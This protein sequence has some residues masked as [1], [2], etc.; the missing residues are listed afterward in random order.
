MV[1]SGPTAA[2][3]SL[4][5]KINF[6]ITSATSSTGDYFFH[7]SSPANTTSVFFQRLFA[8]GTAGGFQLGING[9]QAAGSAAYG[10]TA[11][12]LNTDHEVV[13]K[14][15]FFLGGTNDMLYLYVNPTDPVLTNNIVYSSTNWTTTEPTT[16]A[17]AAGRVATA[18]RPPKILLAR[19][20]L[21]GH[22]RPFTARAH[23]EAVCGAHSRWM[24]ITGS[25]SGDV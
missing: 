5:M 20:V 9:A 21:H 14:W 16:V 2:G 8:R 17:G 11:L 7:L 12:S 15:D 6:S 4:L 23:R 1:D 19:S 3:N 10:A 24:A 18:I 25:S 22:H 13:I